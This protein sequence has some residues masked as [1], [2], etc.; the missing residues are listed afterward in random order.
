MTPALAVE[1]CHELKGMHP[2]FVEE[3]VPQENVD[4]LKEISS[5]VP[6]PIATGERLLTRWGF[7]E[8]FE[9]Q[10]VDGHIELPTKPGLGIDID[11]EAVAQH[12]QYSEELGGEHF[13]ESD[14]SVADW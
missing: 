6:F 8:I 2:M 3:P 12:C 7:R 1:I 10:A 4:A 5:K 11:E 14:G 13:Y 9:K